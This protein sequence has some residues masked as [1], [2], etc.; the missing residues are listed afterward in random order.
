M[1]LIMI[2]AASI[3]SITAFAENWEVLDQRTFPVTVSLDEVACDYVP[4]GPFS[5]E[6][7]YLSFDIQG[8]LG[9]MGE[10][11]SDA[12]VYGRNELIDLLGMDMTCEQA[13]SLLAAQADANGVLNLTAVRTVSSG[14]A[15]MLQSSLTCVQGFAEVFTI[16]FGGL[17]TADL[18]KRLQTQAYNYDGLCEDIHPL[19]SE[20]TLFF[21]PQ[22]ASNGLNCVDVA[23]GSKIVFIPAVSSLALP[24]RFESVETYSSREACQAERDA[25]I[26]MAE[27]DDP[28]ND[29]QR[30]NATRIAEEFYGVFMQRTMVEVYGKAFE[31]VEKFKIR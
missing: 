22:A 25:M 19:S 6:G 31:A 15:M 1:K 18:E 27:Q 8:A 13:R 12:F 14:V 9:E 10:T 17:F 7:L 20:G 21:H 26:S 24:E 4:E 29:G 16:D 5:T 30:F 2:L 23:E 11:N 3:F 28:N